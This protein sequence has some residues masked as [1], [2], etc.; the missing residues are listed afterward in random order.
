HRNGHSFERHDAEE[1]RPRGVARVRLPHHAV[2]GS[3]ALF[4]ELL[5]AAL[6]FRRYGSRSRDEHLSRLRMGGH[7]LRHCA[8]W[9]CD[10]VLA[11]AHPAPDCVR[12]L[13]VLPRAPAHL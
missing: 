6:A 13:L 1:L 7:T 12:H 4:P 3:V 5:S 11:E 8:A 2:S 10:L 9:G